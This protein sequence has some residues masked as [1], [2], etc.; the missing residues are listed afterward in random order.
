MQLQRQWRISVNIP[1]GTKR[2]RLFVLRGF[3][4]TAAEPDEVCSAADMVATVVWVW[5]DFSLQV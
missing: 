1:S 5:K 2:F 3:S 4:A